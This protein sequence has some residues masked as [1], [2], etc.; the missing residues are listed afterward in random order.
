MHGAS[1]VIRGRVSVVVPTRD[2]WG[3]VE[4]SVARAV[5]QAYPD[6]EVLVV[7]DGSR[8][9]VPAKLRDRFGERVRWLR[10]PTSRGVA[11]ARNRG[12]AESTGEW[13]AFLD[14]DDAWAPHH[15]ASVIESCT[16][17][18]AD[19]GYSGC[20]VIDHAS[21][22]LA[23]RDAPDPRTIRQQLLIRNAIGSPS[24]VLVHRTL[25]EAGSGFD[26]R[27]SIMADWDLWIRWSGMAR[28][29]TTGEPTLA[30]REHDD[31]MSL[32]MDLLLAEFRELTHR[33]GA[34]ARREIGRFGGRGF[35]LWV[36]N[37]YRRNGD[38][39]RAAG[40]FLRSAVLGRRPSDLIRAVGVLFGEGAM[41]RL[42][43]HQRDA[44]PA[45]VWLS[46]AAPS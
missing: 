31:N 18:Q 37:G 46:S 28:A 19:F 3:F 29:A 38:R 39:H 30:Y 4:G 13:I 10:Q 2:R 43:A 8:D 34:E 26:P 25:W 40:W 45:P 11:S 27:L 9:E 20:W 35:P 17:E 16:R 32:D 1:V 33:Y 12:V 6:V 22:V 14:D 24:G 21:R 41:R 36:A 7:D 23:L 44:P 5:T 42:A 15:V